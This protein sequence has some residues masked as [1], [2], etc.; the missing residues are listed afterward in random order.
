M[1]Q[2]TWGKLA[3]PRQSKTT[4]QGHAHADI[5]VT[6]PKSKLCHWTARHAVRTGAPEHS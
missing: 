4:P 2:S 3:E 6:A 1:R 5:A